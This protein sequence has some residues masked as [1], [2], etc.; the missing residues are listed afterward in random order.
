M[1][2]PC[3]KHDLGDDL[4][5]TPWV[6][7]KARASRDYAKS[8]YAALCN[9]EF[10]KICVFEALK[11]TSWY[12]SWRGAGSLVSTLCNIGSYHTT[13][14]LDFYCSGNE[15]NVTQEVAE[16]LKKLEWRVLGN[17]V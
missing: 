3:L 10:Q 5:N 8:L 4:L 11:N 17:E 13:D 9:N 15:G 6:A 16:D 2:N 1:N 14:Y 12:C 7:E